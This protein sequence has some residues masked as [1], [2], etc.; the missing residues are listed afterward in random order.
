VLNVLHSMVDK[1]NIN[2]Q[3]EVYSS[4]GNPDTVA[5]EFGRQPL[6]KMMGYFS[7]VG[8]LR[9]HSM[10]GDFYQ[11]ITCCERYFFTWTTNPIQ[12]G[13]KGSQSIGKYRTEQEKH[14]LSCAWVPDH[15]VLLRWFCI[16]DDEAICW[17][18]KNILQHS[19]LYSKDKRVIP[20]K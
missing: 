19:A 20:G 12:N 1:S 14:V 5:D 16:H 13:F 6:Y 17:C 10:L 15:D 4:G 18:N 9:L 7:L 2:R 11:A 3:L 8:L